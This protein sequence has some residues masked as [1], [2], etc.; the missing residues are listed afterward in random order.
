MSD[1]VNRRG[2]FHSAAALTLGSL[3]APA[4]EAQTAAPAGQAAGAPPRPDAD[5]ALAEQTSR[6]LRWA[7]NAP[8]D[9]VRPRA[10]VDHN[11]VIVGGGQ[12]GLA[13]AYGLK[14]KGVGRVEVIDRAAPGETGIWRSIARMHQLR[15][16]KTL[17]GPEL[18][19]PAL[20]FRA[21]YE[22]LHGT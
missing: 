13:I 18:G 22:T 5:R 21:W 14:R 3:A 9:W 19:N 20:S 11:V 15:T 2:F 6:S 17:A 8:A 10:G 4:V 16:P 12:S 7:G 1:Q